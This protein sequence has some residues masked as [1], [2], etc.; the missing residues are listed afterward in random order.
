MQISEAATVRVNPGFGVKPKS[1]GNATEA[2]SRVLL[3]RLSCVMRAMKISICGWIRSETLTV[4]GSL[5]RDVHRHQVRRYLEAIVGR[6]G[7][8]GAFDLSGG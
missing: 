6:E 8:R 7:G 5:I 4:D 3:T 2:G 1:R